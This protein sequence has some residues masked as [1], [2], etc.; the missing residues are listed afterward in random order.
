MIYKDFIKSGGKNMTTII[1]KSLNQPEKTQTPEK[2]KAEIVKIDGIEIQRVTV[3]PGWRWSK[4]LKP[5]VG[6]DSCQ[7][8]HLVYML[9]GKLHAKMIDGKEAEFGPGEVGVIPPGH[10]GWNAGDKPAVWIEILH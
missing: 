2:L 9:S 8:H 5:V 6:G 10:D 1:K 4:H 3:E 7:R